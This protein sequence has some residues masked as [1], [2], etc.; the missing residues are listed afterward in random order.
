MTLRDA[1]VITLSF[2]PTP[3]A[4]YLMARQLSKLMRVDAALGALVWLDAVLVGL[5]L[6]DLAGRMAYLAAGR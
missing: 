3:L 4:F 6:S 2:A 1:L 5:M